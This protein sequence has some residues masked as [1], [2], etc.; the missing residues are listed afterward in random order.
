MD[1]VAA[2]D[3][4]CGSAYQKLGIDREKGCLVGVRPD[5]HVGWVGGLGDVE[6]L[7]RWLGGFLV[8]RGE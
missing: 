6:G 4:E 3:P 7:R 2:H 5:Q 8:E 1:V